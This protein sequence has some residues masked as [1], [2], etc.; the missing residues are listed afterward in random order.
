[1]RN[2]K[3]NEYC[4]FP[5]DLDMEPYTREGL[6]KREKEKRSKESASVDDSGNQEGEE[7][8]ESPQKQEELD[9]PIF[10]REYYEYELRGVLV[11]RGLAFRLDL[12]FILSTL[13]LFVIFIR[14]SL[15]I[16][17]PLL[18]R[19][20]GLWPLLLLHQGKGRKRTMD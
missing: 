13:E 10:P 15:F 18:I 14:C 9:L 8:G 16:S 6:A 12:A 2:E 1:M 11:H 17:S 3:V 4:E 20:C 7:E 5:L 19:R